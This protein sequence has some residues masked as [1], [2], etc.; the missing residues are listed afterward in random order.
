MG[1]YD[2]EKARGPI[3]A[4]G[5]S[6]SL[7][8][9]ANDPR[10]QVKKEALRTRLAL[11]WDPEEA[12]SKPKHELPTL[13]FTF[14]DR[15]LT[16]RGWA[17][18]SGIKYHTLY[19]RIRT[20]GLSLEEALDKGPDGDHFRQPVTAF[21]ETKPIYQ[22]GVDPRANA[23]TSTIR[24]RIKAGWN[25]Q[26]AITEEPENRSTLG[27]GQPHSAWGKRMSLPEWG[28]LSG[29][30]EEVIRGRMHGHDLTLEA[31]LHSLGW[32]PEASAAATSLLTVRVH[33]L[34]PGDLIVSVE[35]PSGEITV[36]RHHVDTPTPRPASRPMAQVPA[37]PP[38][39][40]QPA[41]RSAG[42]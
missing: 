25:P 7:S 32:T 12:V 27:T 22:W 13:H 34:Q 6:K 11:G 2:W 16:L 24:K 38:L 21:G 40:P 41:R 39:G 37:T 28:R 15:T 19:G 18:Q 10:C 29:V 5:E 23:S 17:E 26:I 36:R 3:V 20:Q 35:A 1:R 4:F 8:A 31:A 30:P 14:G 42:R 33:Q 9:W